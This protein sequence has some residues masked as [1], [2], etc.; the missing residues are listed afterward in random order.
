MLARAEETPERSHSLRL[1]RAR[2]R[3]A[4]TSFKIGARKKGKRFRA[5]Y[6]YCVESKEVLQER[7]ACLS[8]ACSVARSL[9]CT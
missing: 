9:G 2:K 3:R 7:F 6:I 8:L 5:L 1:L 4:Y